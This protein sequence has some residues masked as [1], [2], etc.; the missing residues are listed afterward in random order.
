MF[1]KFNAGG[2]PKLSAVF[3]ELLP[4]AARWVTI[5]VLLGIDD[6][7]GKIDKIKS[8]ERTVEEQLR[9]MLSEWLKT[10]SLQPSWTSLANALELVDPGKA[11]EIRSSLVKI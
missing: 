3:K 11:E 9:K 8:D 10:P 4:L 6:Y 1:I 5:G 7:P 2:E